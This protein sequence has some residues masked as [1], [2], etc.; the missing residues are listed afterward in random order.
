MTST[1]T[2]T[3]TF[4][5]KRDLGEQRV[6]R[7]GR[8]LAAGRPFGR[9]EE[10]ETAFVKRWLRIRTELIGIAHFDLNHIKYH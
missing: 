5:V 9:G 1:E 4:L 10:R 8:S 3:H 7:G 2:F 6:G